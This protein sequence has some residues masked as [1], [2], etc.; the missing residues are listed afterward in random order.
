MFALFYISHILRQELRYLALFLNSLPLSGNT[1]NGINSHCWKIWHE[2]QYKATDLTHNG[3]SGWK[4]QTQREE[5]PIYGASSLFSCPKKFLTPLSLRNKF[6]E[7]IPLG[8][9]DLYYFLAQK[10][11]GSCPT[12]KIKNVSPYSGF[13]FLFSM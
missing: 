4:F 9:T 1:V 13:F 3:I 12:Y 8:K 2:R 10:L 6:F 5:N 11:G 7:F